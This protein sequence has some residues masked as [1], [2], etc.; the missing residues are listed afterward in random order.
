MAQ[1]FGAT[2]QFESRS[3]H[4]RLIQSRLESETLK[5][6]VEDPS[7]FIFFESF[8]V[9]SQ[10]TGVHHVDF[11][12]TAKNSFP[13]YKL[14]KKELSNDMS[15]ESRPFSFDSND[16]EKIKKSSPSDAK[17]PVLNCFLFYL[18]KRLIIKE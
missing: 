6:F 13:Y 1:T 4:A 16:I 11:E 12:T 8:L 17:K 15:Y 5:R 14:K 10:Q 7:H 9:L 2:L 18:Q 3:G